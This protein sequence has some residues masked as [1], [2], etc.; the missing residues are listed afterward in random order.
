MT[1]STGLTYRVNHSVNQELAAEGNG[2][3]EW[4]WPCSIKFD[5]QQ[6]WDKVKSSW[7]TDKNSSNNCWFE[8]LEKMKGFVF[9]L[10]SN[11]RVRHLKVPTMKTLVKEKIKG[12]ECPLNFNT[13]NN[14]WNPDQIL[15]NPGDS[16][17]GLVE[18]SN[19]D[20]CCIHKLDIN[21]G[22]IV[23]ISQNETEVI[24]QEPKA[25][26]A[27]A[28]GGHLFP[29]TIENADD[30]SYPKSMSACTRKRNMVT[31]TKGFGTQS[32]ITYL[33]ING[34]FK[35]PYNS[36]YAD[37]FMTRLGK[38][39]KKIAAERDEHLREKLIEEMKS[40]LVFL[41]VLVSFQ[42][43]LTCEGHCNN[44]FASFAD[45]VLRGEFENWKVTDPTL[46]NF[47]CVLLEY[48]CSTGEM[49]NHQPLR[50]HTDGNKVTPC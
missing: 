16:S 24:L 28:A 36:L 1:Q 11:I 42:L 34:N 25:K 48:A 45:V 21:N 2:S 38:K 9:I 4:K 41:M 47:D 15:K 14:K 3:A 26:R 37:V 31:A 33:D 12:A 6:L 7:R 29:P 13:E 46:S 27:G 23:S 50:A 22:T 18:F 19:G 40:R 49:R 30:S 17:Y 5:G 44:L 10:N 32:S 39:E 8:V 35:G 20:F 43:G